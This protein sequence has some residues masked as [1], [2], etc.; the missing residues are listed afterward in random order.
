M[1]IVLDFS[2][3]YKWMVIADKGVL[4]FA[5]YIFI[6]GGYLAY[7][8]VILW[9]INKAWSIRKATKWFYTQKFIILAIDVPKDTEQTPKAIEQLFATLSGAHTPLEW[10]EKFRGMFQLGFS[11]EIVSID[12]YIQFLVR[13][14]VQYRN[15]VE[16]AV[17]SQYP[18]AE[19]TEVEDYITN[20][21]EK[22]PND[23]YQMWG[24]EIVLVNDQAYPIKTYKE[25]EDKVSGEFKD[26]IAAILE[27]MSKI[28]FGEQAWIQII[29]RPA[30][31]GWEKKSQAIVHKMAGKKK[32]QKVSTTNKIIDGFTGL[33]DSIT[34]TSI[35]IS[36]E[37]KDEKFDTTMWNLT[38][39]ERN[40]MEAIEFKASKIAFDCKMR[41]IYLSPHGQYDPAR[42]ISPIFG[43]IKQ[44]TTLNLNA[45]RPDAK[46]KTSVYY[47]L[48]RLRKNMR[49]T[50]L[51]KAYKSRSG[52]RGANYYIL[53]TEELATIW[54][55]PNKYVK[56]PLLQKT[57]AKKGEPPAILPYTSSKEE[58]NITI[59]EE[60][61]EQ[62]NKAREFTVDTANDYFEKKF[63]KEKV[64]KDSLNKL[65]NDKGGP[66]SNLPI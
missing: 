65:S 19:I 2:F 64:D 11:F 59:T 60:L 10:I 31:F 66:P 46:T 45:F 62:L 57:G 5:W 47:Y 18:D 21:P 39:G 26:P 22:F 50:K 36:K 20:I 61:K 29:V 23:K 44:F 16:T 17:F 8:W 3:V 48:T 14:P 1:D 32:E 7:L 33:V 40:A 34:N 51:I 58:E 56:I 27:T 55:F 52:T 13:T 9:Y 4:Y 37:K 28:E 30:D 6:N 12:G 35:M 15:L 25:F 42:V 63:A 41:L 54:H 24:S 38:P 43:S 53:N 49:R